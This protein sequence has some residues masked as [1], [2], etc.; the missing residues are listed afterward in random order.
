MVASGMEGK[1]MDYGLFPL[2]NVVDR[3]ERLSYVDPHRVVA[4]GWKMFGSDA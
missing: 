2:E 4:I 3:A 1:T